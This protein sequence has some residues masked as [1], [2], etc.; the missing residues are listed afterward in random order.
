MNNPSLTIGQAYLA[1]K[2]SILDKMY[3]KAPPHPSHFSDAWHSA[4]S[5]V[6]IAFPTYTPDE[7]RE[8]LRACFPHL[9]TRYSR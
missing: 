2:I 4:L 9:N 3:A 7:A 1:A 6:C 5:A 8:S